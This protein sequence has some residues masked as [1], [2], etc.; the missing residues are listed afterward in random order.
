MKNLHAPTV[1]SGPTSAPATNGTSAHLSFAEL[2][3]RKDNVEAELK[4]LGGVLDS[5]GV[6]MN[7]P[8]LTRDGYPRS[9]VDV[10]Q[11]RTTRARIIRLKNDYKEIM[12]NVEKFLHEHFANAT[13]STELSTPTTAAGASGILPDSDTQSL[14]P[15]F[16]KVESVAT[17]SPAELAG[18]KVGDEV[19]NFGYV[20]RANND[21]L[22]KVAEC[23]Q[24]NEGSNIFIR[25]SR[26]SGVS[27]R[28]DLRLTL[29]P[30]RNWGGRGMLG[31]H[32]T[33]I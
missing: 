21:G 2:Q 32:I 27:S 14:D 10:A 25:V 7:T 15:P 20:N 28:E 18:L 4:A 9:D 23:V 24:G 26:P 8:L 19:R 29:T 1:P 22:K 6:D 33:P 17:N 12:A 5:H 11:I 13:E 31:C 3:Q 16:A 30:R